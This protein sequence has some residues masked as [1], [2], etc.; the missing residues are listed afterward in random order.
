MKK[1]FLLTA[2]AVAMLGAV[3][4]EKE[5]VTPDVPEVPEVPESVVG[6][7]VLNNGSQ[8]QNNSSLSFYDSEK[9]VVTQNVFLTRNGKK[10]GDTAQDILVYGGK[11]YMT[12]TESGLIFVTDKKGTIIREIKLTDYQKPRC[13]TSSNGK[14]YA[15][16]FDGGL[17]QIDTATFAVKTVK[18]GDNP[19]QLQVANGKVYVANSGGLNYPVYGNTVSVVD[20]ATLSVVKTL[21]VKENPCY[22]E[23][24]EN[25]AIYLISLGDY[26]APVLQ[27]ID[28]KLDAV[29]A[30][31]I[32]YVDGKGVKSTVNPTQ[33]T[34]VVNGKI[35]LMTTKYDADWNAVYAFYVLNAA[36]DKI[37]RLFV[38]DTEVKKPYSIHAS[39]VS[40]EVYIGS[41]DYVNTGDMYVF[42]P[43][44][45]LKNKFET[46]LNP[47]RVCFLTNK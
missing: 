20:V 21:T 15:S 11:M 9:K 24:G 6:V 38:P 16:Y 32:T 41:S 13:L 2:C 8:G 17:A 30:L 35:Y 23:L 47:I 7:Y 43:D 1:F 25:G 40:G 42:G 3:S 10:L 19:E 22:M 33:M 37:E 44:G 36:T 12:V 5:N 18:V 45:K 27:K 4:C 29:T 28:S 31:D 14:V 26:S 34:R 46:G 39:T